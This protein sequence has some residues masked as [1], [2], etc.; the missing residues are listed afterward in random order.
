MNLIQTTLY[1]KIL[2][3]RTSKDSNHSTLIMLH[4]RGADENDLLGLAEYLDERLLI[5]SARAPFP[6]QGGG[7][8]AWYDIVGVGRPDP[9]MFEESYDMLVQFLGDIAQGYP[10]DIQRIF[11]LG[12]SM[13]T[14]MAYALMLTKPEFISGVVANSG[15][16]PEDTGLTFQWQ[17]L[18]G[19]GLFIAHGVYDPVIPIEFGRRAKEL[20]SKTQADVTY[21]EYP[22]AHQ[23]SEESLKDMSQWLAERLDNND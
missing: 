11:L 10:V 19:K 4:G 3:P 20:F 2:P 22:M 6:F 21:K 17:M 14:M 23:I 1:H 16:V 13:G 12:F 9:K 15:Y 7:G 8:Y 5:I 18:F